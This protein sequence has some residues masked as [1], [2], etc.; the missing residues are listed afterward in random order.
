MAALYRDDRGI[1]HVRAR[2]LLELAD[3]QGEATARDRGWQ[4]EVDRLRGEGRLSALVG[5]SAIAW[6]VFARRARLDDT[7]R[8]AYGRTDPES[9]R[10][11][12]AY[13][14]G[15]RRGMSAGGADA[16][17]FAL[18]DARFGD[19]WRGDAWHD[20]SPLTVLHVAHALFSTF[21]LVFWREHVAAVLGASWVPT[22]SGVG[23]QDAVPSS[24]SNAWALTGERTGGAPVIAGDPHRLFELPGVYQQVRLA[25]ERDGIDV[26]GLAFPGVPGVAHFG[27][28]GSAAWG[29]THAMAHGVEV[30]R[31]RL[32][33]RGGA[34]EAR[35]PRGW[36]RAR[37]VRSSV[38]VRGADPV[39]VEAIETARG[40][41]VTD[42]GTDGDELVGW[43]VRFPARTGGD[44]GAASL[45]HLL[46]ARTAADVV[47][48]FGSWVEP[49]N[50]LLTADDT[51]AV[52]SATVGA[53]PDV[54]PSG[55]VR[56]GDAATATSS[57]RRLP[58]ARPV[59][60]VAVDANERP[61]REEIDFGYD[62]APPDRAERLRALLAERRPGSV[63]DFDALWGDTVA[64]GAAAL[65][66]RLP[67]G[68]LA[69]R[70]AALRAALTTWDGRMDA[71]SALAARFATW[72][73]GIVRAL[74]AHP[75]LAGLHRPHPFGAVFDP[76]FAVAAQLARFVDAVLDHPAIADDAPRIVADALVAAA[77]G[78]DEA[79]GETHRLHPLHVLA[80]VDGMTAP[81]ADLG[82]PV[83]GDGETVRC[84]ASSPGLSRRSWRGS[85]ARWAWDLGDRERSRWGVPFGAAGDPASPH[86]ADQLTAWVD[87]SP[88]RVVTAWHRLRWERT[89]GSGAD[90]DT[91][92]GALR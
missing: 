42:L 36:E 40:P 29:V 80:E 50:R 56:A 89:I 20:H 15:V 8:R 76:W 66:A 75:A 18:L 34:I 57:P 31:E 64:P 46:G 87:A 21:P 88:D 16:A 52:L 25:A 54:P 72:R 63:D 27:H 4:I 12:A 22:L 45:R 41:V 81:G 59:R 39:P 17:E 82:V 14:A 85:V 10:F 44:L 58:A 32:R 74:A 28:T 24:G 23:R 78:A 2:D 62:Y 7:A 26:V 1:P 73:E 11:V 35:G 51:G 60:D 61:D 79:W 70:A 55:R 6:D 9:A 49:V 13:A 65:L 47:A 83:S 53:V 90:A 30:F 92:A 67:G 3:A 33:R 77:H 71:D 68:E 69:P 37:V 5:P 86:F 38:A 91:A 43:S 84:T 48:A 19:E